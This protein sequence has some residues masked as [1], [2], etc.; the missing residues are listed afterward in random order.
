MNYAFKN[1][2]KARVM[3]ISRMKKMRH[4]YSIYKGGR[5]LDV[6]VSGKMRIIG[7]NCFLDN[8]KLPENCYTGLGVEDLCLIKKIFPQKEFVKYRGDYFPFKNKAFE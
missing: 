7:E 3:H 6:G 4:F 8:F 5:I 1:Y 2:I